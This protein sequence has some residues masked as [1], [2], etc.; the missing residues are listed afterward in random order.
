MLQPL[1]KQVPNMSMESQSF[2]GSN[3]FSLQGNILS[4]TLFSST[5]SDFMKG[6][7][8]MQDVMLNEDSECGDLI[9][10]GEVSGVDDLD[11][12]YDTNSDLSS[13][14]SAKSDWGD[15]STPSST[16]SNHDEGLLADDTSSLFS[17]CLD[18]DTC[19]SS[20]DQS[21]E[22]QGK[23]PAMSPAINQPILDLS[24]RSPMVGLH[25]SAAPN[26]FTVALHK[27]LQP[28]QQ[29]VETPSEAS[30]P[31]RKR[32]ATS[33]SSCG[34][35]PRKR[36][37][38]Y[39]SLIQ[40]LPDKLNGGE[41]HI[42]VQPEKHHR[43]RYRTEGSRGSVKDD[44]GENFPK[45]KLLGI[46]QQV[47]LQVFV[48]TDQGKVRP[49]GYYQACKVTGRNTTPSEEKDV[50]GTT[51]LEVP[52]EPVDGKMEISVDCI[53]ILKLRNADVEQRI[54]PLRSKRKSTCVRLAF[55]VIVPASDGS[56]N[57]VQT[58]SRSI[59]CTQPLGHPEI[60]KKS[61]SQ[62]SVA[63][64]EELFIIG[65][66]FTSKA[67]TEVKLRQL[68]GSGKMTW[69]GNCEIDKALFQNNH[70]VC[71]IPPYPNQNLRTPA[72]VYL[73][74]TGKPNQC[75]DSDAHPIVYQPK[76]DHVVMHTPTVANGDKMQVGLA[77]APSTY[78]LPPTPT[79]PVETFMQVPST[80]SSGPVK[81][82]PQPVIL[83]AP[84]TPSP[85][86]NEEEF[87]LT[88]QMLATAYLQNKDM[89]NN[90]LQ[91]THVEDTVFDRQWAEI[92][93][94]IQSAEMI[95]EQPQVFERQS[96]E[97]IIEQPE[98]RCDVAL[99]NMVQVQADV[100]AVVNP[101]NGESQFL[102]NTEV[103]LSK[104]AELAVIYSNSDLPCFTDPHMIDDVLD[105]MSNN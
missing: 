76:I 84:P 2:G 3:F 14:M 81:V 98:A 50:E 103:D 11:H 48:V 1:I 61:L 4:E 93:D 12:G 92:E 68:D 15:A 20:W 97:M 72:T 79:S 99:S 28:S 36:A 34:L 10:A 40:T 17:S 8:L 74:V 7:N 75:S 13:P 64:G 31:I 29:G 22:S 89:Y 5:Q 19:Y 33:L 6:A 77:V 39:P 67:N 63:G 80:V 58:V 87:A 102:M 66:N 49:H 94:M 82:E 59:T 46:N 88:L 101:G 69:E 56:F 21:Y 32:S 51:V 70:I 105:V 23:S 18:E 85:Q 55:R 78:V 35:T 45:L 52:W 95:N 27:L 73:V 100:P 38:K 42:T 90:L 60:L 96:A 86:A 91:T 71:K 43:A 9:V 24:P 41:I 53:G 30:K 57:V 62:C 16:G 25:S 37:R 104:V 54:G 26:D 47:L 83:Q 65:K 44:S